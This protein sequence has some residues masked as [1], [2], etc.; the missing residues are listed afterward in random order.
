MDR[1]LVTSLAKIQAQLKAPKTQYNSFG[2]YNYRKAEDILEAVKPLLAAEGLVLTLTDKLE[3]IGDRYYVKATA[4][5]G[6][7]NSDSIYCE[8]Y[9]REEEHKSGMDAAQV[10]GSASS[11]ARKYALNGLFC[12]DDTDD[13]D[14][15][16]D[17]TSPIPTLPIGQYNA[18]VDAYAKG[19]KTKDGGDYRETLIKNYK[20]T[21]AQLKAFDADVDKIRSGLL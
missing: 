17:G 15:T 1:P 6:N 12:I 18:I 13:P 11:Y 7:A 10:T 8:A 4:M 5:V 3:L 21:K 16:N 14:T 9:A 2:K 20:P 19:Q